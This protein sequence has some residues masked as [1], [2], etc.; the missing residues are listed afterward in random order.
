MRTRFTFGIF[1]A[2]VAGS[3]IQA[4]CLFFLAPGTGFV[5][6]A[7]AAAAGV[8]VSLAAAALT[9]RSLVDQPLARIVA[10][11][12]S[13]SEG[14]LVSRIG[15]L[16]AHG[17]LEEAAREL[18]ETL[19]GNYQVILLGLDELASKNLAGARDFT[20]DIS[21]AIG[22]IESARAPIDSMEGKVSSLSGRISD[23]SAEASRVSSAVKHLAE[24]V[25]DQAGA[26]EQTGAVIE[27]T[28]GQIRSIA[29]TANRERASA[30]SLADVV[31]RGGKG[32]DAVVAVIDGLASG[33]AEIG[34][35]SKMINQVASRTNLLAMNAAIEAAHA[36]DYGRGFAVVAEEIR[37][38]AE[39]A[40]TGSKRIATSLSEFTGRIGAAA[41]ANKD[42]KDLFAGLRSDSERFLA[43]FSGISD[44]TS[45]IASGTAQMVE[46]VQELRTI[47]IENRSAFDDMGRSVAAL[48]S[49]FD[50][51]ARLARSLGEDGA[52]MSTAF[53]GAAS[54]V[55][56]LGKRGQ[57]S[58]RSFEEVATELR[59]FSL[60]ASAEHASYRP[61]IKRIIFD[62]KRR[63][64]DGKLFL[65]GRVPLANLPA[66][67]GASDC[68]LDQLLKDIGPRL[69]ERATRLAE[70][71]KAHHAF[72]EAYNAFHLAC[73]KPA[74]GAADLALRDRLAPLFEETEKRWT[75]LFDYR[76]ELNR[77]L[78]KLEAGRA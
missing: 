5:P 33:V 69:P 74:A 55:E 71:D 35:L 3:C 34:E 7:G 26:V 12:R 29:D 39:S 32:V 77:L 63:V 46:G 53:S 60:D 16:R 9:I 72:H 43:A 22:V 28:S 8:A 24:R 37:N 25:A 41:K 49:L 20:A 54:R 19:A 62:H 27:E 6:L 18:D 50:E 67:C 36:G 4:L 73:G 75:A 52:A 65:D 59:Y 45:E 14:D 1:A 42:L 13:L 57:E 58:Q 78:E 51:T 15:R 30:A 38:L 21:S 47:S 31:D 66:R 48:D 2:I 23:A 64:V 17:G 68:I 44:G 61:E 56:A 10:R 70:L 40:G 11:L 76:E